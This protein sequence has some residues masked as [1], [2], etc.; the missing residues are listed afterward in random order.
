[1]TKHDHSKEITS[2]NSTPHHAARLVELDDAALEA[3][4]GGGTCPALQTCNQN[5]SD[6]P[7]LT[8]CTTNSGCIG[9]GGQTKER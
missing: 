2:F 8:D 7:N 1:M 4:V 3:V 5:T 6:C 9:L